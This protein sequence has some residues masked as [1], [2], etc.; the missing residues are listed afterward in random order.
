MRDIRIQLP[1]LTVTVDASASGGCDVIVRQPESVL[2]APVA[3]RDSES[4]THGEQPARSSPTG[5]GIHR[6]MRNLKRSRA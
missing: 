3:E 4:E 6:T 5:V 1:I 2:I